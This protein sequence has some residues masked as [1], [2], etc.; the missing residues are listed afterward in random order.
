MSPCWSPKRVLDCL[1][2]RHTRISDI[3]K[4]LCCEIFSMASYRLVWRRV[5]HGALVHS[6]TRYPKSIISRGALR[7]GLALLHSVAVVIYIEMEPYDLSSWQ[8]G[9]VVLFDDYRPLLAFATNRVRPS[10]IESITTHHGMSR[11]RPLWM[12]SF[13]T[14]V[15]W[16]ARI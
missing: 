7:S 6:H 5:L 16:Y 14:R 11:R 8:L 10:V 3:R 15:Y 1:L 9:N 12:I 13:S 4:T 2:L